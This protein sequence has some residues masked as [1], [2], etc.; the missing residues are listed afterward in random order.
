M[1]LLEQFRPALVLV[2]SQPVRTV[3]N[4][5]NA[6]RRAQ[7]LF[8]RDVIR[9]FGK[10]MGFGLSNAEWQRRIPPPRFCARAVPFIGREMIHRSSRKEQSGLGLIRIRNPVPRATARRIPCVKSTGILPARPPAGNGMQRIP[11]K[12]WHS[13]ARAREAGESCRCQHHGPARG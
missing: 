12:V 9:R 3:S 4:K 7:N 11:S 2:I 5:V 8:R 1:E 6:Q 10:A 13:R